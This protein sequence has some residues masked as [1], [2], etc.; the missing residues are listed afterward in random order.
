M[1]VQR[2]PVRVL[3]MALPAIAFA[4]A[5]PAVARAASATKK[6][7]IFAAEQTPLNLGAPAAHTHTASAGGGSLLRTILAL[8]VVI[9]VIY[10]VAWLLRRLRRSRE[11]KATGSGLASAATL[12]LGGGRSLHLVRAGADLIL[13]GASEHGVTPIRTYTEEE[14]R[15]S[16]LLADDPPADL[17][18]LIT[19]GAT[20]WAPAPDWQ[21]RRRRPGSAADRQAPVTIGDAIERLRRFTVRP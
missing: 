8:I 1:T 21:E 17:A 7:G 16:G 12:P 15:T 9:A 18:S 2:F 11:A 10:G 6:S 5:T 20:E 13:V 14:A 4:C 19:P 3:P